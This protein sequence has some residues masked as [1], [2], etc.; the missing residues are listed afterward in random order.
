MDG[1]SNNWIARKVI[2]L[3]KIIK[4]KLIVIQWSFIHRDESNSKLSDEDRRI[5]IAE[6]KNINELKIANFKLIQ[7][8]ESQKDHCKIVHSF[9]PDSTF[10]DHVHNDSIWKSVRDHSWPPLPRTLNEFNCLDKNIVDELKNF[11]V[12]DVYSIELSVGPLNGNC[13]NGQT[14]YSLIISPMGSSNTVISSISNT[15]SRIPSIS[16]MASNSNTNSP[17][18]SY[19]ITSSTNNSVSA[20]AT[21]TVFYIGNWT[22]LG[23]IDYANADILAVPYT[24]K[25]I[26]QC[27]LSC[28]LN[29]LCGLIGV[30]TP[31]TTISLDN[32]AIYTT[33]CQQCYLKYTSGWNIAATTTVK[34]IMLY[35]RVY[36][37]TITPRITS[38][39]T[40][41]ALATSSVATYNIFPTSIASPSI[42]TTT[43]WSVFAS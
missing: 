36:P 13:D 24:T 9:V 15:A 23:Q 39:P 34:S 29:P 28:W 25:T 21:A 22:D 27:Q 40:A 7:D 12:Y 31:C 38:S 3:L 35:D 2:E 11:N 4:P 37:P 41:S 1:A 6:N 18:P 33:V 16:N 20:T 43:P 10:L 26:Y 17:K 32:P 8:I 30:T 42:L 5:N 19:S 14:T